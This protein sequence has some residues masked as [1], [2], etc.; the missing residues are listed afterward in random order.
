MAGNKGSSRRKFLRLGIGLGAASVAGAMSGKLLASDENP[1]TGK[2]EK[3]KVLTTDGKLI[4]IDAEQVGLAKKKDVY[5]SREEA[6]KGIPN[7]KFVMV[8]DLA[9]CRNARKCIEAA[10]KGI[11]CQ[12]IMNG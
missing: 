12:R 4:E 11:N 5:I 8:I 7:R 10:R 9:K 3:V 2:G 6:R 1:E